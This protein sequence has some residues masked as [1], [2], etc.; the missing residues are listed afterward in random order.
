MKKLLIALALLLPSA[1]QA[2]TQNGFVI[3]PDVSAY[4]AVTPT[5]ETATNGANVPVDPTVTAPPQSGLTDIPSTI[6]DQLNTGFTAGDG[7]YK[8]MIADGGDGNEQKFRTHAN[9]VKVA[10]SDPVRNYGAQ[11]AS[12]LHEFFGNSMIND[13]S[14]FA[15]LRAQRRSLAGGGDVNATGYWF[16]APVDANGKA[17]KCKWVTIYYQAKRTDGKMADLVPGL[18]YVS[19]GDMDDPRK[20][21]LRDIVT[22]A[23]AANAARGGSA[24]RYSVNNPIIPADTGV[25]DTQT[26]NVGW[27]CTTATGDEYHP[28][29]KNPDNSDPWAGRCTAAHE[30]AIVTDASSCWDGVNLW[31]PG[32]YKHIIQKI[33]DAQYSTTVCPKNYYELPTLILAISFKHN[34]PSDY[35]AWRFSSDDMMQAKIRAKATAGDAGYAGLTTYTVM[36]GESGHID[37]MYG[38]DKTQIQSWQRNC[39]GTFK[40]QGHECSD[41]RNGPTTGLKRGEAVTIFGSAQVRNPQVTFNAESVRLNIPTPNG[42]ATIHVH[43][44]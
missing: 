44:N 22:A 13:F 19:G 5:Y 20:M 12:H 29:L 42:P 11:N 28:W 33:Y 6:T 32:G 14:T 38:W 4:V 10:Y 39:V 23:N 18:R 9:C 16:P 17:V 1:A 24:T 27:R 25:V 40:T 7:G 3:P 43:G 31:S 21:W 36:N 41:G 26:N 15:S 2:A 37:W 8:A 30:L 35:M 34:G